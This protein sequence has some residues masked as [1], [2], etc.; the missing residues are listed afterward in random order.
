LIYAWNIYPDIRKWG[1]LGEPIIS[2]KMNE[3]YFSRQ[4]AGSTKPLIVPVYA[5]D[6]VHI[7][8][9]TRRREIRLRSPTHGD[10]HLPLLVVLRLKGRYL[11]FIVNR[12]RK[13][14][15]VIEEELPTALGT[16]RGDW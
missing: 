7:V 5:D 10:R 9:S 15:I 4:V 8:G 13:K 12:L 14:H 11:R 16:I 6:K 1:A 2:V 3:V